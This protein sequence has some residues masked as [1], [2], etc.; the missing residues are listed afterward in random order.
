MFFEAEII[1]SILYS[2]HPIMNINIYICVCVDVLW[3]IFIYYRKKQQL[4][5]AT[6]FIGM[7]P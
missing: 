3:Y 6:W 1:D 4:G 7:K 2:M 5:I